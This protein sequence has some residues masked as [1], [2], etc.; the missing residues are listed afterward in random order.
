MYRRLWRKTPVN[1]AGINL[2]INVF[3]AK[4]YW[5]SQIGC[6]KPDQAQMSE[7]Q[8]HEL[9][10]TQFHGNGRPLQYEEFNTAFY[11][12]LLDGSPAFG[13]QHYDQSMKHRRAAIPASEEQAKRGEAHARSGSQAGSNGNQI[14]E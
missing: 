13:V 7:D 14:P 2:T 10:T 1:E 6:F 12:H 3:L 11:G 8:N 4:T 9:G 5:Q